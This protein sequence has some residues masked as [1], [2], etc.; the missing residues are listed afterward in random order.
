LATFYKVRKAVPAVDV[1]RAITDGENIVIE[2]CAI[3][4]PLVVFGIGAEGLI[5][6]RDTEF[7]EQVS[8]FRVNFNGPSIEFYNCKFIGGVVFNESTFSEQEGTVS[9]EGSRF[10]EEASFQDTRFN[11]SVSFEKSN[12][13]ENAIFANVIFAREADFR[14]SIFRKEADFSSANFNRSADFRESVFRR[15]ADFGS[16]NF[17]RS[18]DFR[19]SVF[20]RE[21]DF[22]SVNFNRS[23]DFRL[24]TFVER[25]DFRSAIFVEQVDFAQA[26]LRL[27]AS[28]AKVDFRENTIRRWLWKHALRYILR[29]PMFLWLCFAS[30][31]LEIW[32]NRKGLHQAVQFACRKWR[33]RNRKEP[34]AQSICRICKKLQEN[35]KSICPFSYLQAIRLIRSEWDRICV[36]EVITDFYSLNTD[37]VVDG[38]SNPYLKRYIEEEQWLESWRTSKFWR[39]P[40]F[41]IWELTSHCGRSF[42]LWAVWAVIIIFIFAGIYY[43]WVDVVY[44]VSDMWTDK[45]EPDIRPSE[46]DF[47]TYM[48]YSIVTF[49]T[50]GFGDVIPLNNTARAAVWSEVVLGYIMLAV[51]LTIIGN[52]VAR[53]S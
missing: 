40:V 26:Y 36:W 4:G 49:T 45:I 39:K 15:E 35:V 41:V 51:L 22:G 10:R 3:S 14:E 30:L 44:N 27:P 34:S 46:P 8:F 31:F 2:S 28:F 20:R 32:R 7:S 53:P 19:E 47:W 5:S 29:Y 16:A 37:T 21:A 11:R 24:A 38:S 23:V 50:L 52:R 33:S 18:A 6:I 13:R 9:F 17:N 48:Y 1:A 43:C 25:V 12:F 42:W